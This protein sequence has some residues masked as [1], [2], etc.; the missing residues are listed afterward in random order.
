MPDP[1]SRADS[2]GANA[3]G[4]N[5]NRNLSGFVLYY[6]SSALWRQK[7]MPTND[8]DISLHPELTAALT[9]LAEAVE[10]FA[11]RESLGDSV[12][13]NLNLVLDELITNS[14]SYSLPDVDAPLLCLRLSRNGDTVEAQLEDNGPAFDP[15]EEAPQ[16]DTG[17]ALDDRPIG[18]LGVFLVKQFTDDSFYERDGEINRITM[19]I[20]LET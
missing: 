19:R 12:P 3:N 14:I 11:E 20:K 16:P 6:A 13:F 5:G 17:Q 18:G 4:L 10:E 1:G 15:F 2:P 9:A 7:R 8:V